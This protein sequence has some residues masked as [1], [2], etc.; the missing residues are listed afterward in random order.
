MMR[1]YV[2]PIMAFAALWLVVMQP[3]NTQNDAVYRVT[4]IEVTH[5]ATGQAAEL[6]TAYAEAS[7]NA[8]GNDF[9]Q[10]LQRIGRTNHFAI[11][12][13]W[14]SEQTRNAH[15]DSSGAVR[16]RDALGP[17]LLSPPDSRPYGD[18]FTAG[19]DDVG[20]D[21]VFVV[22]H[23]DVFPPH[24]DT[25]LEI[26]NTLVSVSRDEPG[27]ARF[28]VWTLIDRPNHTTVVEAWESMDAL[29]R[30]A[31]A[32]HT[33]AFR[34]RLTPMSGALYDERLYRVL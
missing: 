15:A 30:H 7:Q 1:R 23:V 8:R 19:G 2:R 14:D 32:D 27:N 16:F 26:L 22:T 5:S 29:V 9:F 33:R 17:L 21:G 3:A 10:V 13:T 25:A 11:L 20:T 6:L 12:E 28:E 31:G 18:L 4:Y 34:S 24:T